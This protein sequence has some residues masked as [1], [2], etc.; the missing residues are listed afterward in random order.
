VSR[1]MNSQHRV[2]LSSSPKPTQGRLG[3]G[4]PYVRFALDDKVWRNPLQV[5]GQNPGVAWH[6]RH[7]NLGH[8]QHSMERVGEGSGKLGSQEVDIQLK[9]AAAVDAVDHE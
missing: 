2:E 1:P 4:C 8:G 7:E 9:I 3:G 5:R 6:S